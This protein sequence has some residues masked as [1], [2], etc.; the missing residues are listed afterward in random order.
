MLILHDTWPLSLRDTPQ[1][2]FLRITSTLALFRPPNI[3][4]I[5]SNKNI[6]KETGLNPAESQAINVESANF[7]KF[8]RGDIDTA[9]DRTT[10]SPGKYIIEK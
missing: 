8:E 5:E 6:I 10:A 9:F 2:G 1:P 3:S 4:Y 7:N